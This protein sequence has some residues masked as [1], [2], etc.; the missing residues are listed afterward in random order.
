MCL[1]YCA[2]FLKV[3]PVYGRLGRLWA[4]EKGRSV[5]IIFHQLAHVAK[6]LTELD[7]Y[8]IWRG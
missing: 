7:W 1:I 5:S 8:D 6:W 2:S 3:P 4:V